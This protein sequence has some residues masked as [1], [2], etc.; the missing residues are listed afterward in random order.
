VELGP[1]Q[2]NLRVSLV[3]AFAG[4][5]QAATSFPEFALRN[6]VF[7]DDSLDGG[8][9]P[10]VELLFR[11][12]EL[13]LDFSDLL[14]ETFRVFGVESKLQLEAFILQLERLVLQVFNGSRVLVNLLSSDLLVLIRQSRQ[15]LLTTH[16][17]QLQQVPANVEAFTS[18][19]RRSGRRR[20]RGSIGLLTSRVRLPVDLIAELFVN[21]VPIF[22][23]LLPGLDAFALM[24]DSLS[25]NVHGGFKLLEVVLPCQV[26]RFSNHGAAPLVAFQRLLE[27]Y[28]A[29]ELGAVHIVR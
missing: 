5:V 7:S 10:E 29:F 16:A 15:T 24:R 28:Q 17:R 19:R 22:Q 25:P 11:S 20:V 26:S 14:L 13:P 23:D 6:V 3:Q 9:L 2:P 8:L 4:K 1:A 12:F 27:Q 18:L 21:E